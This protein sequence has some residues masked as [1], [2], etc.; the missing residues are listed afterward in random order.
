MQ[1]GASVRDA[2]SYFSDKHISGAPIISASGNVLGFI[3][4][5]DIMRYLTRRY[6]ER[7]QKHVSN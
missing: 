4:A 7:T 3:S 6:L 5:G 2:I 1:E